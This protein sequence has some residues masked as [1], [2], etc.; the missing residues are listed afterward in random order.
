MA[1]TGQLSGFLGKLTSSG[2]RVLLVGRAA[3]DLVPAVTIVLDGL[4]LQERRELAADVLGDEAAAETPVVPILDWTGG[5]PALVCA[6]PDVLRAAA[7][8]SLRQTHE[9]LSNLPAGAADDQPLRAELLEKCRLEIFDIRSLTSATLP[10]VLELYK[11]FISVFDWTMFCQ[12]A[13][14]KGV[15]LSGDPEEMHA[16]LAAAQRAGLACRTGPNRYALHPLAPACLW[17]G[18]NGTVA[19]MAKMDQDLIRQVFGVLWVVYC[20]AV[21]MVMRMPEMDREAVGSLPARWR[22]RQNLWQATDAALKGYLWGLAFP[23]LRL[24]RGMLLAEGRVEE[25]EAVLAEALDRLDRVPPDPAQMGPEDLTRHVALLRR[26]A[27]LLRDEPD[28]LAALQAKP[29]VA[30]DPGPVQ[31]VDADG[32]EVM[33]IAA[34]RQFSQLM[35]LGDAKLRQRSAECVA[36]YQAALNLAEASNDL[37][38]VGEAQLALGRAH[39][40]VPEIRDVATYERFARRAVQTGQELGPL[41]ADLVARGKLGVGNAIAEQLQTAEPV[42]AERLREAQ[43]ALGYAATAEASDRTTR[44]SARNGLG[45]L[46]LLED[47]PAEAA[48]QFLEAAVEFEALNEPGNVITAQAQAALAL[49]GRPVGGCSP[50]RRAGQAGHRPDAGGR[51]RAIGAGVCALFPRLGSGCSWSSAGVAAAEWSPVVGGQERPPPAPGLGKASILAEWLRTPKRC[52]GLELHG[53]LEELVGG[54]GRLL[55]Q[56]GQEAR[57]LRADARVVRL[58]AS[59]VA[60]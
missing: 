19:A 4:D 5:I 2:S 23:L 30:R 51:V 59:A 12:L 40:N 27:R 35:S 36:L 42:D 38:R 3:A 50:D 33:P 37:L 21:L 9:L 20:Q 10:F 15:S 7:G 25:W 49:A 39:L 56:Q 24:L 32:R 6:L 14:L 34:N 44:A 11:G 46:A 17:P 22:Q 16:E 52:A 26:D 60:A 47:K 28:P 13:T 29:V 57:P 31:L 43:A 54:L 41:G 48:N 55:L 53:G 45:F 8:L 58:L 18:Y 1:D